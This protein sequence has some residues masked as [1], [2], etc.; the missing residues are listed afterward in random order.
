VSEE[1][2]ERGKILLEENPNPDEDFESYELAR[3]HYRAC[4]NLDKLEELGVEPL[5]QHLR[6]IGGW[7]V[8]EGDNWASKDNF[9][10][11]NSYT[12]C[13]FS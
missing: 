1:I 8:L 9:T 2:S 6:A 4:T 10:W 13:F 5:L 3:N 12:F 7:P 11:Y